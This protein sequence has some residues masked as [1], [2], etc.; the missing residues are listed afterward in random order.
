MPVL[1]VV[2]RYRGAAAAMYLG[3]LALLGVSSL[4]LPALG[5][6]YATVAMLLYGVVILALVALGFRWVRQEGY[7]LP[8]TPLSGAAYLAALLLPLSVMLQGIA[9]LTVPAIGVSYIA[10]ALIGLALLVLQQRSGQVSYTP[11]LLLIIGVLLAVGGFVAPGNSGANVVGIHGGFTG[12]ALVL[13]GLQGIAIRGE[14]AERWVS[15]PVLLI[16]ALGLVTG[17]AI[18]IMDSAGLIRFGGLVAVVAGMGVLSSVLMLV[19]GLIF[20]VAAV[21]RIS[22]LLTPVGALEAPPPPPP[23]G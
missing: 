12:V 11:L 2:D 18:G 4:A 22:K 16:L 8:S 19:A 1:E 6:S 7:V 23:P 3:G 15:S 20:S 14:E 5:L 21:A 10:A 9:M 17:S 13:L